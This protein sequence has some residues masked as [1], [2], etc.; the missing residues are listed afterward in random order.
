MTECS[1]ERKKDLQSLIQFGQI[2]VSFQTPVGYATILVKSRCWFKR[3]WATQQ[4]Y[5]AALFLLFCSVNFC[6]VL[7][8]S[9][10]LYSIQLQLILECGCEVDCR[11]GRQET[12]LMVAIISNQNPKRRQAVVQIMIQYGANVSCQNIRGQTPLMYAC[13]LNQADTLCILMN[14]VSTRKIPRIRTPPK[15]AVH[16]ITLKFEKGGLTIE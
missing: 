5:L 2:K 6:S 10:L 14:C 15:F 13:V 9:I 1:I 16:V 12:P 8:N 3:Q 4:F 7:L 11:N